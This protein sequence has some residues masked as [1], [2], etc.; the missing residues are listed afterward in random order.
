MSKRLS[1]RHDDDLTVHDSS[2]NVFADLGLPH[3][4][5]RLAK[6]LLARGVRM[7]VRARIDSGEWNQAQAA[8]ALGIHESDMSNL[9]H[10]KLLRFSRERVETFLGRLGMH[11]HIV[12]SPAAGSG[13][14]AGPVSVEFVGAAG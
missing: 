2:G 12:V 13:V 10:G 8:A 6:A 3:A 9:M 7:L 11:V 5:E 4:E 14:A 1:E